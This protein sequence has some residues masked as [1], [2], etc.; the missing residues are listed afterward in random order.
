[1]NVGQV[2]EIS[3]SHGGENKAQN[4]LGCTAVFLIECRPTMWDFKFSRRPVWS[5]ESSGMYCRVLNW[6]STNYVRFQVLTAASMTLRIFWDVLPC[7]KLNVD[8]L[9]EISSSHGG[10]YEAQNLLGCT[11]VFLIECRPTMWDCKFSRRRVWS[12]ESSGMY[13]QLRTRQYIPEDSELLYYVWFTLAVTSVALMM[14]T[15]TA[16]AMS[17]NFSLLTWLI[18]REDFINSRRRES[19][20]Y[21]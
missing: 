12:S 13:I 2:C 5:S 19:F 7:S 6:I 10:Q 15:E 3:S 11:A 9:C 4:L 21:V 16:P 1:M 20:K 18:A 8:Q 17:A 14:G